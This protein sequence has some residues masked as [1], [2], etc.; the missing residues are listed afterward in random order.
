MRNLMIGILIFFSAFLVFAWVAAER[1]NPK[2]LDLE[3][4]IHRT[5]GQ[6][7]LQEAQERPGADAEVR[8]R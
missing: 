8:A 3:E 6:S 2:M 7:V 4:E 5:G 1:A